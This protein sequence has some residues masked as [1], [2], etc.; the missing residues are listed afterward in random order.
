MTWLEI[1][2][3]EDAG[4]CFGVERA[5]SMAEEAVEDD[6]SREVYTLGPII[7]NPQVVERLKDRGVNTAESVDEIDS[8]VIIIRSHGVRPDVIDRARQKGLEII[9]A[10]CPYV[11]KAQE[12]ARR[13]VEEDYQTIIYGDRDHPEVKGIMGA[14]DQRALIVTDLEEIENIDLESSVGVVAQTTKSPSSFQE[15]VNKILPRCKEMRIFNTI[16]NTTQLRQKSAV[17]L[18]RNVDVMFVIGGYN[19]ANTSRLAE[20][21]AGTG[22]STYHIETAE[23]IDFDWLKKSK[24]IGVTAGASTPDWLIKEVIQLMSEEEKDMEM[25]MDVQEQDGKDEEQLEN[26]SDVGNNDQEMEDTQ[27]AN[28]PEVEPEVSSPEVED[29]T[30]AASDD[31]EELSMSE[32]TGEHEAETDAEEDEGDEDE[33][34]QE[35]MMSENDIA[36]LNKGQLIEGTVVEINEN[37][38]Y[39][40]VNYKSDG[41]INL[42][43]LSTSD[44]SDPHEV[45]ELGE[46]IK[47]VVLTLEDED[48][49]LILSRRRAEEEEAW[50]RIEESFENDEVIEAEITK[51]VKGG[52]V[53]D[54]GL[55]GFIPASHV[56]IGY[57]EDLSQ[58]VGEELRLKVIEVDRNNNNVVLSRKEVLQ[59]EREKMKEETLSELEEGEKVTGRVTKLVDFGAFVDL[60]GIEGLLHISEMSWGRIGH[61]SDVLEEGEEIEVMVL[62]VDRDNERISLGLKQL[63][64]DPWEEFAEK[65]YEGEIV[66]GKITKIVDFGAFMEIENG[67]EGL[68][69]ISQL[70]HRH[71]K[72]PDEVVEVE[73]E[74]KA[75]I[76]NI[77]P[78][79]RR[80]GLSLKELE[81][82][83][84]ENEDTSSEE[85]EEK[86]EEAEED[87]EDVPSGATI[88]ERLGDLKDM[89]QEE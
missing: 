53:A 67:I 72:T 63:L 33:V 66:T 52:L 8:G 6:R 13:L 29:T 80:V 84:T 21:C 43:E 73:E 86:E 25:E 49:N 82:E 16:C 41:F 14:A 34:S 2:V 12:N 50:E 70:S 15:L 76:I 47:A 42:R 77:D 30:E 19:S 78:D 69:H 74:R 57:V 40:D 23:D 3:A 68:I 79:D 88:G 22:T 51:E 55:R 26:V 64:P 17:D 44:V 87:V 11:K 89:M 61:P 65:H 28:E 36:D 9:D 18:A 81:D 24:K 75:K 31:V 85:T 45:V 46:E 7:H 20:M 54:V 59:K 5:I 83:Q 38:V 62:E 71:V 32:E 48:G 60:G 37:G 27:L 58:Y 10:T 39:V 35:E 1:W 4:F 56:A